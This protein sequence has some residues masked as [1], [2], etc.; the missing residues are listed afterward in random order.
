MWKYDPE[1]SASYEVE[2]SAY[3]A[4][5]A[6][7]FRIIKVISVMLYLSWCHC[8]VSIISWCNCVVSVMLYL[9]D[10]H[11]VFAVVPVTV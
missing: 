8:V 10:C 3:Y 9:S 4:E 2:I 7:N 1:I 6:R 11:G 5:I